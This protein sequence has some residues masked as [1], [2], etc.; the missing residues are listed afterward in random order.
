MILMTS[1]TRRK[2]ARLIWVPAAIATLVVATVP[3][4]SQA[5]T[6][7]KYVNGFEWAGKQAIEDKALHDVSRTGNWAGR[8]KAASGHWYAVAGPDAY[9]F[10]RLG[11][12]SS[13][14]P[15]RGYTTS[16]DIYL[17][18]STNRWLGTDRRFDWSSAINNTDGNH[19]RDFIFHVGTNPDATGTFRVSVSNNAPG[20]PSG[21][22]RPLTISKSGWYKFK[23]TFRERNGALV[24]DMRVVNPNGKV[25]RKW[26]LSDPS[27]IIGSTVGG[28]R[29]VWLVNNDF[30]KLRIDD[31]KR[32]N[33]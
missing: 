32:V 20:N 25:L 10:S 8:Y 24:V 16:V 6:A 33:R 11:G 7:D 14:F 28:N 12:Y 23:Q 22:D 26:T 9:A 19:R 5:A 4:A 29:Y 31:L 15:G 3:L 18:M 1:I 30:A 21:G 2:L 17:D 27:D 13:T